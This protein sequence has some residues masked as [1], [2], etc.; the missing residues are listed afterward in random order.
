MTTQLALH[1][2]LFSL[3]AT[4]GSAIAGQLD[5]NDPDDALII[6]RKIGCSV[7]DAEPVTF[8][9]HGRAYSRR[10]GEPDK[11]LFKVEGMN[12]RSC[13]SI[14]DPDKGDGYKLVSREL[15]FYK[16][17][18]TDEVLSTWENPWTGETVDVLHVANDP[19]N[20]TAYKVGRDGNPSTFEGDIL[21]DRWW[22]TTEV[23]LW[24]PNPLAGEYQKE[25][26]G[27]YHA[28]E[29][30]NFMGDTDSLFSTD[31]NT[32]KVQ[33]GWARLSDWLPWMM[34]DGREGVIYMHTAGR[35][36]DSWDDLSDTIKTEIAKRYPDY[37]APPPSDDPRRNETSWSYYKKVRDGERIAPN[38]D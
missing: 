32:A 2:T 4:S 29:M 18:T 33:V 5:P 20:F 38:R 14:S 19:V 26:G 23:P 10:Q 30:F 16:D 13:A 37:V 12:I 7:I 9:W 15:L 6:G 35:K 28:T 22:S 31:T 27:T 3:I 21:G 17:P 1:L 25:I 36:L 11:L 8:W 34:M 24:Y